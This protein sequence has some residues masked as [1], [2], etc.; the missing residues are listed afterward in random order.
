MVFVYLLARPA[1]PVEPSASRVVASQGDQFPT[2]LG[3]PILAYELLERF[4]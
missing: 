2:S 3:N 4:A 1:A